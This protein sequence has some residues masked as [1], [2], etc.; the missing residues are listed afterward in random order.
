[1]AELG[2]DDQVVSNS[3]IR[4]RKERRSGTQR[5]G[6]LKKKNKLQLWF[7]KYTCGKEEYVN[8]VLVG[9]TRMI[10]TSVEGQKKIL[11]PKNDNL[12]EYQAKRAVLR[13]VFFCWSLKLETGTP[14]TTASTSK[15]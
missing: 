3:G 7:A 13:R 9:I 12:A 2:D 5:G 14:L 15:I 6:G 4:K 8:R 11:V 1:M 10:Y